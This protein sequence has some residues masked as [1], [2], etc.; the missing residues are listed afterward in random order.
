VAY[1]L[2]PASA[3]V[4]L[5]L[6]SIAAVLINLDIVDVEIPSSLH[7]DRNDFVWNLQVR[8]SESHG[9]GSETRIPWRLRFSFTENE[10]FAIDIE[11]NSYVMCT[12]RDPLGLLWNNVLCIKYAFLHEASDLD[13]QSRSQVELASIQYSKEEKE[14]FLYRYILIGKEVKMHIAG[15]S[16]TIRTLSTELE[17]I[18]ALR[19]VFGIHIPDEAQSHIIGRDAALH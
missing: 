1:I 5:V 14:K 2:C 11:N 8:H 18:H 3:A 6:F 9:P 7:A 13:P 16:V 19:E 10:I 4:Y 12:R 17:R 15:S